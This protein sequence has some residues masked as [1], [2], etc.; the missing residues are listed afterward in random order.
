MWTG[1]R[2]DVVADHQI[3][4]AEKR[5]YY[6]G[7][8]IWYIRWIVAGYSKDVDSVTD[9]RA[10]S[11]LSYCVFPGAFREEIDSMTSAM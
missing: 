7:A 5:L 2:W 10:N 6:K 8:M 4:L 9:T 1:P 3:H 11:L